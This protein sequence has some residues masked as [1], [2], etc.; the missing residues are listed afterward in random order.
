MAGLRCFGLGGKTTSRHHGTR[1]VSD[2][3]NDRGE[4][5]QVAEDA[6]VRLRSIDVV[7]VRE[8]REREREEHEQNREPR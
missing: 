7:M 1:I 2:L 5:S 8:E 6:I 4:L 3:E